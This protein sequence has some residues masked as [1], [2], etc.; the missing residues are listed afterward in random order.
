MSDEQTWNFGGI[1]A[2]A[3]SIDKAVKQTAALLDRGTQALNNLEAAWA[4]DGSD[5]YQAVQLRWNRTSTELNDSLQSLAL[6][7][8]EAR[9]AMLLTESKITGMFQ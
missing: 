3:G 6:R 1:E 9:E 8:K 2:G 4:G 5:A 7:I